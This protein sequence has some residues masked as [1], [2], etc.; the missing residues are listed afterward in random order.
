[1][2][3]TRV[4]S[5]SDSNSDQ[6]TVNPEPS[7]EPTPDPETAGRLVLRI[8]EFAIEGR[9]VR[10]GEIPSGHINSTF[11]V[12]VQRDD[13][14]SPEFILQ[15]I[16]PR[17]FPDPEAV[18]GN[19]ERVSHHV[20]RRLEARDPAQAARS[21]RLCPARD[22]RSHVIDEA[23]D[24]WRCFH[25]IEGCRTHD[26][27]GTPRQ[28]FEAARAFGEFQEL[29]SDFPAGELAETIPHFHDTPRRY[30]RLLEV[31]GADPHGRV[32]DVA[33]E[34]DFLR[35]R[36]GDFGRVVDGL[37]DGSIPRRVT[38]NDTKINNVMF[39]TATDRA[40]CVI[41]LDTVMPG[42]LLY[43]FGD[44]VRTSASPASEDERDLSKITLRMP[45]LEELAAG[46][47]S[48][49]SGFLLPSERSLLGFSAW[50]ITLELAVR[51]L[52]DHLEGDV[53]FRSKRAGH[54]LDRCRVH[55]KLAEAIEAKMDAI[56]RVLK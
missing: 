5:D 19:V 39:D 56:E 8:S 4:A 52:T 15:R 7:P 27:V 14:S 22:G 31:A 21:L 33:G 53:Y 30:R 9:P 48:A 45:V 18:M 42:S 11:R 49:T 1:M 29:V 6:S 54:N 32:R 10:I 34:L 46:Y 23:G 41:D 43:D 35:E 13:G 55:L 12:G 20:V 51:F 50:L 3:F 26:V 44:L 25:A 40:V 28:A 37:R 2:P 16:N 38:H 47:L 17:V 36:A 24:L